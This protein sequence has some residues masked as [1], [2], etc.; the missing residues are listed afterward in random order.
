MSEKKKA[1][2][3]LSVGPFG[4]RINAPAKTD[5]DKY[6]DDITYKEVFKKTG[7]VDDDGEELGVLEVKAIVKKVDISELI[8]SQA[9]QVGVAAYMKALAV[10]GDSIDNYATQVNME[11]INDFSEMPDRLADVMT[12]GDKAKE[13]FANMDPALKG[14]HT[15]IEGFLNSLS[16]DSIDA[17]I[18]GRIEA[19]TPKKENLK[20]L[21]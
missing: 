1:E 8:N 21:Q 17:Y 5:F 16:K 9:D 14:S 20:I 10:Q 15:T 4:V 19:L 3:L 18:K 2:Q 12:A 13:V 6:Y 7:Q 11:K